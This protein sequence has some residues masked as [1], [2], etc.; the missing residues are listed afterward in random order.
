MGE[1]PDELLVLTG[2]CR[3]KPHLLRSTPQD[4]HQRKVSA[5]GP[6]RLKLEDLLD[7][8][9]NVTNPLMW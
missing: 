3:T 8:A 4:Q 1:E 2:P 6:E 9:A 7:R 5:Q